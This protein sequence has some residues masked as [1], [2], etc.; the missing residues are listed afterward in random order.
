MKKFSILSIFILL[1]LSACRDPFLDEPFIKS[2]GEDLELSNA[3]FLKKYEDKYSLWI[4]LLKH[5]D[6]FNA[7][8]DAS[9]VSTVFAPDNQAVEEFLEWRGV[10]SVEE[11][12]YEYARYVAQVHILAQNLPEAMFIAYVETGSIPI[13]TIFGT[14]LS[15]SYG[16]MDNEVDDVF[17]PQVKV[18]DSL[19]IYL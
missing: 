9:S 3:E 1:L 19:S 13:K 16:F 15:T 18:Q 14:Y 7:L 17:L 8:N 12:D 11:L 4:Q 5:A 10:E 2:T 6:M